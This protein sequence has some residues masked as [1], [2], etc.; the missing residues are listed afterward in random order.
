MII[1]IENKKT[2]PSAMKKIINTIDMFYLGYKCTVRRTNKH[3]GKGR[4]LAI[5]ASLVCSINEWD[6][7]NS[8]N[9]T[10]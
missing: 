10:S 7:S 5:L 4:G 6:S 2:F 8:G 3:M 9:I 1:Y